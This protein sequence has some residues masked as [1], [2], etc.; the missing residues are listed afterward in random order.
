M[1]NRIVYIFVGNEVLELVFTLVNAVIYCL[2]SLIVAIS[3]AM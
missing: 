1:N 3:I 2:V